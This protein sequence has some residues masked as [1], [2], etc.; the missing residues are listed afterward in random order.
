M[1]PRT[2]DYTA[3]YFKYKILTLIRGDFTNKTLKKLQIELEA[4]ASSVETDL[5]G[6]QSWVSRFSTYR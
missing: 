3:S 4:N 2:I 6:E 1:A 5:E